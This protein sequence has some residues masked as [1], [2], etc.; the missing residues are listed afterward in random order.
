[1]EELGVLFL[2]EN[3][4]LWHYSH[5][6]VECSSREEAEDRLPCGQI[7]ANRL[8]CWFDDE[9]GFNKC[10]MDVIKN[11]ERY[12]YSRPADYVGQIKLRTTRELCLCDFLGKDLKEHFLNKYLTLII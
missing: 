4:S 11:I 8:F 7:K 5:L 9:N 10:K 1:M 3:F 12:Y 2:P 6:I